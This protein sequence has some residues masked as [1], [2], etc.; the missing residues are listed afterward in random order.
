MGGKANP[1]QPR[2]PNRHGSANKS[3]NTAGFGQE[4]ENPEEIGENEI[5][6]ALIYL[7]WYNEI[8][9]GERSNLHNEMGSQ[10]VLTSIQNQVRTQQASLTD[11]ESSLNKQSREIS[12]IDTEVKTVGQ[13]VS[14]LG[15]RVDEIEAA[16]QD[17]EINMET[18][19]FIYRS[20]VATG[21]VLSVI[22]AAVTY[23]SFT[24]PIIALVFMAVAAFFVG[25][26]KRGLKPIYVS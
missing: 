7:K 16:A 26:F 18:A 10:N 1:L 17:T 24:L 8:E 4:S 21:A 12:N 2:S 20:I 14:K 23:F 22:A 3:P 6:P 15:K 25:T 13:R 19:D 9:T 5:S 11:L